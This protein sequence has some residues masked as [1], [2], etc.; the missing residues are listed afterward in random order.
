MSRDIS[1]ADAVA[2]FPDTITTVDAIMSIQ[3]ATG[4]LGMPD[5]VELSRKT[6]F[7][8]SEIYLEMARQ[9]FVECV[10][11][12]PYGPSPGYKRL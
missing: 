12:T 8:W 2:V 6:T 10:L 9:G 1:L 4:V 5:K 3:R 7:T 11:P